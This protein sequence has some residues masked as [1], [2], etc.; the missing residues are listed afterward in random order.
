MHCKN[1]LSLHKQDDRMIIDQPKVIS[2]ADSGI[3][4]LGD[5]GL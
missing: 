5:V 3:L 4:L 1:G 2:I